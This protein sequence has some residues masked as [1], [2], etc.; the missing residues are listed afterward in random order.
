MDHPAARLFTGALI[1]ILAILIA[2]PIPLT[3]YP[4]GF[5]LLIY[6]IALI[7]RDGIAMLIAWLL[8]IG[9]I[10]VSWF[11]IDQALALLKSWLA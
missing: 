11:L 3:N 10:I 1:F 7:E 4:F 6:C 2:L 8:G 5:I 9:E